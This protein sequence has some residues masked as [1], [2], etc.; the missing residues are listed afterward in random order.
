[1]LP[2]ALGAKHQG[3][4]YVDSRPLEGRLSST[5]VVLFWRMK[6]K[7]N[8][9][10]LVAA[11]AL[12]LCLGGCVVTSELAQSKAAAQ[13]TGA[14][15]VDITKPEV[16]DELEYFAPQRRA[17]ALKD[18][19]ALQ[20]L[21][22]VLHKRRAVSQEA[23]RRGYD[24][25]EE[26][27]YAL[28]RAAEVALTRLAPELYIDEQELPSFDEE[29]RAF[30][31]ERLEAEFTPPEEVGVSHILLQAASDEAKAAVSPKMERIFAEIE[32]GA[33]FREMAE[34][35]SQ[36]ASRFMFGDLGMIRRGQMVP[37]FE[38]VAFGLEKPGD[39]SGIVESRF[40][41]HLIKLNAKPSREPIPYSE[42]EDRIKAKLKREH[43]Q[44][45]VDAWVATLVP[46]S[47]YIRPEEDLAALVADLRAHFG[48]AAIVD[49]QD[50]P[51]ETPVD[52]DGE[53]PETPS[54]EEDAAASFGQ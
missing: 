34:R 22:E 3:P 41:L 32:A 1:M 20:Q 21:L 44:S 24:Q 40:G 13:P 54:A 18:P 37:E 51:S 8:L 27:R 11:P 45:L 53:T 12:S 14:A 35:Y 43:Q 26:G 49:R 25:T 30:Y 9:S 50:K 36:D 38:E 39:L 15:S 6:L 5:L 16:L 7:A 29:A 23:V 31:E 48:M 4:F 10:I 52:H 17:A 47:A 46:E 33:D 2:M 28:E 19:L 42:V